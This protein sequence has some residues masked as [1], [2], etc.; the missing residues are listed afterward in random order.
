MGQN[1]IDVDVERTRQFYRTANVITD[2][3][4]C[5]GC[6]NYAKAIGYFPQSVHDLFCELGIDLGK[7]AEIWAVSA[8]DSGKELLYGGFYHICG[9]LLSDTDVWVLEQN[10]KIDT[11]KNQ[12]KLLMYEIEKNYSIGFTEDCHLIEENFP[13][14]VIQME[15]N[16]CIPWVL[17]VMNGY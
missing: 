6:C 13:E 11:L 5:D 2:G 10:D 12:E 15:I 3:C 14:P 1:I 9:K 4:T 8:F 17:E 16:F 7:A